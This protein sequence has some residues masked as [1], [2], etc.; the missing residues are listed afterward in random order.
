M[1]VGAIVMTPAS[2]SFDK[3]EVCALPLPR[4]KDTL[5]PCTCMTFAISL[6]YSTSGIAGRYGLKSCLVCTPP[7]LPW[8]RD[9][10]GQITWNCCHESCH[11]YPLNFFER[12]C[13]LEE[14]WEGGGKENY[15]EEG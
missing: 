1:F 3:S 9:I 4:V 2:H 8:N 13:V 12:Y 15:G 6:L 10:R 5:S 14:I 11:K 7:C